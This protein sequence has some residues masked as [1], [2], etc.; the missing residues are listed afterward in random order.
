MDR[1]PHR[2]SLTRALSAGRSFYSIT[3]DGVR[4]FIRATP[5]ASRDEIAGLWTGGDGETRLAVKVS[6]P[7][8]KGRANAA[9]VKLLAK[10]IGVSKSAVVIVAG[11][12]ARLKTVEI[13]GDPETL[14]TKLETL[15]A[16]R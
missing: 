12:T 3:D 5:G 11:E 4:L 10:R 6:A 2:H 13:K 16:E 9:I 15:F 14:S 1:R 7:P 8:D